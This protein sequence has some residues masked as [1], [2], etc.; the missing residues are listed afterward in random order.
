MHTDI[1]GDDIL[2]D[3]LGDDLVGDDIMGDD[4]VGDDLLVG[5]DLMGDEL[6]GA[7]DLVGDDLMGDYLVGAAPARRR[8]RQMRPAAAAAS[9]AATKKALVRRAI[10]AK[11][12]RNATVVHKRGP[13]KSRVQ[14]LGF[15][16]EAIP[17]GETTEITARPQVLFRGRRLLVGSSIASAFTIEDIKV[18]RNSQFVGTGPQPAEA[19]RDTATG[20]NIA[21]DTCKPGVDISITVRN[22]TGAAADFR[23][24]L[25]GDVVE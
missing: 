24:T 10:L 25:F 15:S 2:G 19:F 9:A 14:P 20:D 23:A 6:V 4:D 21:L 16:R 13:T 22:I 18:G 12:L 7:D 11:R 8:A 17:P 5:D 1:M 3:E